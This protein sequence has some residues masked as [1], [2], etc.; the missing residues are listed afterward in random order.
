MPELHH[1]R[2]VIFAGRRAA[3]AARETAAARTET[4]P[5]GGRSTRGPNARS[6]AIAH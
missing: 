3:L 5:L 6:L 1:V 2:A 4:H